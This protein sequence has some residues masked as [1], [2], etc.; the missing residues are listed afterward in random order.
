MHYSSSIQLV[1]VSF[2]TDRAISV[3]SL[4]H[5]HKMSMYIAM[6]NTYNFQTVLLLITIVN[7]YIQYVIWLSVIRIIQCVWQ[8]DIIICTR[9]VAQKFVSEDLRF[10]CGFLVPR[11]VRALFWEVES[12]VN[13]ISIRLFDRSQ[14]SV[15]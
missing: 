3:T 2:F 12:R 6:K 10:Q 14:H 5:K 8:H 7:I 9:V 1:C 4:Q 11:Y 13:A 15:S